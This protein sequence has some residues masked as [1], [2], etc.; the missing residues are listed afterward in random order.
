MKNNDFDLFL[1]AVL[2]IFLIS[3]CS[4]L[5][6]TVGKV[7][8]IDKKVDYLLHCKRI[9]QQEFRRTGFQPTE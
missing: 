6:V 1:K 5:G 9:E 3:A 8:S 4:I 2:G 7:N